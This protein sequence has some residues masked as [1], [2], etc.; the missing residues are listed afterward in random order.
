MHFVVDGY[1]KINADKM[2]RMAKEPTTN[3]KSSCC[4]FL[5]VKQILPIMVL[6]VRNL[7]VISSDNNKANI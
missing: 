2:T 5:A 1:H 4:S 7:F 6:C 3:K